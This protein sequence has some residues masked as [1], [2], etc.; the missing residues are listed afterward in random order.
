MVNMQNETSEMK[1]KKMAFVTFRITEDELRK[2]D[3]IANER[4]TSRAAL[5]RGFI[6]ETNKNYKE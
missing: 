1:S 5:I 4:Q 2:F 6:I 3:S